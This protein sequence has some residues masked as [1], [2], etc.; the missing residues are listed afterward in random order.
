MIAKGD[1]KLS[2]I[3]SNIIKEGISSHHINSDRE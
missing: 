1:F 2:L 3:N